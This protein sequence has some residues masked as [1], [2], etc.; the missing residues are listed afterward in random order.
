MLVVGAR[1]GS[2]WA[3][4][5]LLCPSCTSPSSPS[6]I[7]SVTARTG[8]PYAT[9]WLG[10]TPTGLGCETTPVTFRLVLKREDPHARRGVR[11]FAVDAA[12]A[13]AGEFVTDGRP[14]RAHPN[15]LHA[16]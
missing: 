13:P 3:I 14:Y 11:I 1:G 15:S 2:S 12:G 5:V 7:D 10:Q 9:D 8:S 16:P 6:C 4:A